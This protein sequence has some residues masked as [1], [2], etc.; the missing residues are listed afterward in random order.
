MDMSD[1]DPK[2]NESPPPADDAALMADLYEP[3]TETES[4]APEPDDAPAEEAVAAEPEAQD[5][6]PETEPDAEA[7]E[8]A[9]EADTDAKPK[10]G[11]DKKVEKLG[12]EVANMRR[13]MAELIATLKAGGTKTTAEQ[14]EQIAEATAQIND[15]E[16]AIAELSEDDFVTPEHVNRQNK[17][18]RQQAA[19]IAELKRDLQIEKSQREAIAAEQDFW[20]K[21]KREN[22]DLAD[23]GPA[24]Y[25][26]AKRIADEE[27]SDISDPAERRGANKAV[28]RAVLRE[29]RAQLKTKGSKPVKSSSTQAPTRIATKGASNQPA[30][31]LRDDLNKP[32]DLNSLYVSDPRD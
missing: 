4:E 1:P 8:D 30:P 20:P 23:Q 6:A 7:T 22:P 28:W 11:H 13:E 9:P 12:Y 16:E 32:F 24:L 18:L 21:F 25:A 14:R 27:N 26:E 3:T 10:P 31:N 15:S 29:A 19:A 17:L 5:D 2:E